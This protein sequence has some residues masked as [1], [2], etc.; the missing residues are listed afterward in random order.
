MT[1]SDLCHIYSNLVIK[2]NVSAIPCIKVM[3]LAV[4][5]LRTTESQLT[6]IHADLCMLSLRAKYFKPALSILDVDI[7]VIATTDVGVLYP[8]LVKKPR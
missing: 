4:E 8:T 3:C 6:P 1:V 5:K 2:S 7:T